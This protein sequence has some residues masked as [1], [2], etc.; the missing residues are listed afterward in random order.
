MIDRGQADD[1]IIAVLKHDPAYGD[2]SKLERCT[3]DAPP[4]TLSTVVAR[5]TGSNSRTA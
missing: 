3:A 5:I 1:N 4:T 2:W